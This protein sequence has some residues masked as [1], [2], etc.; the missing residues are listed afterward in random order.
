MIEHAD[1]G[2]DGPAAR[3]RLRYDAKYQ[4]RVVARAVAS[5]PLDHYA[6]AG[7]I[8]QRQHDA[9]IRLRV[10]LSGSWFRARVTA[11]P[12]YA[13]DAGMD[14]DDPDAALSDEERAEVQKRHWH[15]QRDAEAI[16]GKQWGIISGVCSGHWATGYHGGIP[17]LRLG[18][19]RLADEWRMARD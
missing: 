18:L 3:S 12:R 19:E 8:T 13:S 1:L 2:A 5:D 17:A 15:T 6:I 4:G 7:Q 9:G 14:D 16:L 11:T 10:A